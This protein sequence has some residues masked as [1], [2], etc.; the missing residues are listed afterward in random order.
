MRYK[1]IDNAASTSPKRLG[2]NGESVAPVFGSS[3][4][5]SESFGLSGVSV[6]GLL[7][8]FIN[9]TLSPVTFASSCPPLSVTV[10]FTV[11]FSLS[12]SISASSPAFSV[13]VYS[14]SPAFV[15]STSKAIDPSALFLAVPTAFVPSF[16]SNSH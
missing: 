3:F 11:Y 12:Y 9:V 5:G 7:Y 16:S 2:N 13:R 6:V 10:T 15:Y 14:Y 1:K 8:L 4:L